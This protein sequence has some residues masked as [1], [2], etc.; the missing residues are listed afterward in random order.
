[1]KMN[2]SEVFRMNSNAFQKRIFQEPSSLFDEW[3]GLGQMCT[4]G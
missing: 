1:M 3:E 2:H 4:G